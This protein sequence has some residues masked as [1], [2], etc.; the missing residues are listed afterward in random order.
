MKLRVCSVVVGFCSLVLLI[1]AQNPRLLKT[2]GIASSNSAVKLLPSS[3]TFG[4][5]TIGTT[6]PAQVVTLMNVGAAELHITSIRLTGIEAGDFLQNHTCGSSLA[7][8]ANCI[9]RVKFRP[10]A[11]GARTATLAVNDSPPARIQNVILSGTG[12]AGMCIQPGRQCDPSPGAP[13]CCGGL[14]CRFNGGSTRVGYACK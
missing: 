12:A 6:S 9:I 2:S 7:P 5:V 1:D 11:T 13:R 4:T 3:L 10:R 14:V 8:G